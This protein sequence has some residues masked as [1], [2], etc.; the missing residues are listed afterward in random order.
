VRSQKLKELQRREEMIEQWLQTPGIPTDTHAKLLDMLSE[1]NA[2]I[3]T[4]R[5]VTSNQN[6]D[7]ALRLPT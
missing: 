3:R 2:E 1:V 4:N 5:F 6:R 7:G